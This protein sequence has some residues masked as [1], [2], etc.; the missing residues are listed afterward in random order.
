MLSPS[1]LTLGCSS[2]WRG[3]RAARGPMACMCVDDCVFMNY[4]GVMWTGCGGHRAILLLFLFLG[5]PL[6]LLRS[7]QDGNGAS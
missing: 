1:P 4:E 5:P 7:P 6:S 2:P 3:L